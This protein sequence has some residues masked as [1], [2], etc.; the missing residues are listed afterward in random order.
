[1]FKLKQFQ[2]KLKFNNYVRLLEHGLIVLKT[3]EKPQK[4]EI[5]HIKS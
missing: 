2:E 3:V 5:T 4:I 1:M